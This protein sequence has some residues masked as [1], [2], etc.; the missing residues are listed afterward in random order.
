MIFD[1]DLYAHRRAR[2][3]NLLRV[4]MLYAVAAAKVE[5]RRL[6]LRSVMRD[7]HVR[8]AGRL[9]AGQRLRAI[10]AAARPLKFNRRCRVSGRAR[11]VIRVFG[12]ARMHLRQQFHERLVPT[13]VQKR[14]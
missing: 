3:L 13:V 1:R 10:E 12:L 6:I 4:E 8:I 5:L 11:Q 7:N 2:Q 9:A 14:W